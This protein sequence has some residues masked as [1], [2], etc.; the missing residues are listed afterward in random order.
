MLRTELI[1]F[2]PLPAKLRFV[3]Y[4]AICWEYKIASSL[5][6]FGVIFDPEACSEGHIVRSLYFSH[7]EFSKVKDI[8]VSAPSMGLP[9]LRLEYYNS[10]CAD[11][12]YLFIVH[13]SAV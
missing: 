12:S 1:L 3:I 5:N 6:N 7:Q 2:G 13:T 4:R 11:F 8:A 9:A 10:L